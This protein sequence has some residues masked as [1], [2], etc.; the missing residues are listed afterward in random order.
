MPK[1]LTDKDRILAFAFRAEVKDLE[2]AKKVIDAAIRAKK[3]GSTPRKRAVSRTAGLP[4]PTGD[5]DNEP[6]N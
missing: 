2:D 5:K 1:A 4:K 6:V 3:G